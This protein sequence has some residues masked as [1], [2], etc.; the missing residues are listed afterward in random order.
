MEILVDYSVRSFL[1]GWSF[2]AECQACGH[3]ARIWPI[4]VLKLCPAAPH[5]MRLLDIERRLRCR[6]CHRCRWHLEAEPKVMKQA[7]VEGLI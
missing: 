4:D 3:K 7:F 2:R 1:A 6:D 5:R